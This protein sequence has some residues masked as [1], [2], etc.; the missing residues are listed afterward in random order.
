MMGALLLVAPML[1]AANCFIRESS[2]GSSTCQTKICLNGMGKVCFIRVFGGA[3]ESSE[4][5]G[6][7]GGSC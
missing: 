1:G 4:D 5:G 3:G 7:F 6:G 2:W